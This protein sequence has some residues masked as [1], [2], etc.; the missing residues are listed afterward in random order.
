MEKN[1]KIILGVIIIIA[2][3]AVGYVIY[4]GTSQ[5]VSTEPIKI[6]FMGPLTGEVADYGAN[7]K[8]AVEIA[9]QEINDNGG[10]NGRPIEVIYEDDQCIGVKAADAASKLINIDKVPVILGSFCSGAT[11]AFAP[12]AERAKVVALS[13]C[14]TNPSISDAGD[15]IFRDVP[16]DLMQGKFAA[17]YIFNVLKKQKVSIIYV[18][19]DWGNG[20]QKVFTGEFEKLGGTILSVENYSPESTDLR[21]QMVKIKSDKPDVLYFL[22]YPDGTISGIKQAKALGIDALLFGGD[23][24]DT[25]STWTK[26][27]N[28][29]NGAMFTVVGVK[30]SETFRRKMSDKLKDNNIVYCSNY[31]YDGL[32][33]L[34]EAMKKVGVDSTAVKDELYK[35]VYKGGVSNDEIRFDKNGDITEANYTVKIIKNG[36]IEAYS[37]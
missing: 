10:I 3:I 4:K 15:Y 6:G 24:W 26:L 29:G 36:K 18:N 34:A 31:A 33:I 9:V 30:T 16:S 17:N 25:P 7:A 13:Y 21:T 32:K 8:A 11:M 37:Q 1:T 23:A 5:P 20:L 22:G 28:D 35:I 14:S 19:N 27:G 2:A 12:I